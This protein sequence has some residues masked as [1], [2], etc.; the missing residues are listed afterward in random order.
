M[1]VCFMEATFSTKRENLSPLPSLS[2]HLLTKSR[3]KSER[4]DAAAW[5]LWVELYLV[6]GLGVWGKKVGL[7]LG[8]DVKLSY[9]DQQFTL[10]FTI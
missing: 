5:S 2:Y 6:G 9:T 8:W 4:Y 7:H 3:P 10:S 1:L